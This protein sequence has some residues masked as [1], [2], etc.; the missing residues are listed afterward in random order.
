MTRF[1]KRLYS[2]F[3]LFTDKKLNVYN[4][5]V[6]RNFP[7]L[8]ASDSPGAIFIEPSRQLAQSQSGSRSVS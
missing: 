5:I 6:P 4:Y 3:G 2:L 8:T 1:E 7:K